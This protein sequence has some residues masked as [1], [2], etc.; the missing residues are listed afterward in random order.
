MAVQSKDEQTR[1]KVQVSRERV[2][3]A[4]LQSREKVHTFKC[5]QTLQRTLQAIGA[6]DNEQAES[7]FAVLQLHGKAPSLV[8]QASKIFL[9]KKKKKLNLQKC[10][11]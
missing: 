11:L 10:L 4:E 7:C 6:P 9:A 3:I 5:W 8:G 1:R 2:I